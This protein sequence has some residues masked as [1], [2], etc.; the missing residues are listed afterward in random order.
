MI[1]SIDYTKIEAAI[2]QLENAIS[3]FYS[4]DHISTITLA[5]AS[6]SILDELCK[7][8]GY[9][10]SAEEFAKSTFAAEIIQGTDKDRIAFLNKARNCLK[11]ADRENEDTFEITNMDG[12]LFIARAIYNLEQLNIEPSD[13]INR[14]REEHGSGTK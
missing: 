7:R 8:E 5:G 6:V 3:A 13:K 14:F 2:K 4:Q 11:H 9:P 10:S 1:T 12:F